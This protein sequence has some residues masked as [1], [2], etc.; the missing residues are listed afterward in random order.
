MLLGYQ[1]QTV[2]QPNNQSTKE[3]NNQT[4][5]QPTKQPNNQTT[6][7]EQT[8]FCNGST[9]RSLQVAPPTGLCL[10]GATASGGFIQMA[11]PVGL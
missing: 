6:A 3:I 9:R 11:P 4:T 1:T 7:P 10:P 2:K 8:I 5:K